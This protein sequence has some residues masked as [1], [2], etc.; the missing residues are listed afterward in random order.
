MTLFLAAA[1]G[2]CGL[3]PRMW[4]IKPELSPESESYNPSAPKQACPPNF[5]SFTDLKREGWLGGSAALILPFVQ[6]TTWKG[7]RK[8]K[9]NSES[10]S[11]WST[12]PEAMKLAWLLQHICTA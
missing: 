10:G 4:P 12:Q 1:S 3:F 7:E 11:F 9:K 5:S 6:I 2:L 8:Q